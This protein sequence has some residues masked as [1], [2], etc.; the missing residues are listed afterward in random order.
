MKIYSL[1][2]GVD[3]TSGVLD[4]RFVYGVSIRAGWRSIETVQNKFDWSKIDVPINAAA[5][6]NKKVFFRVMVGPSCPQ[7]IFDDPNIPRVSFYSKKTGKTITTPVPWDKKYL[8]R[9]YVFCANLSAHLSKMANVELIA[10]SG[11][12]DAAAN[13][14]LEKDGE[15]EYAKA[16]YTAQLWTDT[17]KTM[18]DKHLTYFSDKTV[19]LCPDCEDT[20]I[21]QDLV[22]YAY[23]KLNRRRITIQSNGLNGRTP[24]SIDDPRMTWF[25]QYIGKMVIGFQMCWSSIGDRLGSLDK[26]I[27]DG[28]TLGAT[29]FEIYEEDILDSQY[30]L[31][32]TQTANRKE[33]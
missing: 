25:N 17:W 12:A 24:G 15:I 18:I 13:P 4:K 3:I 26:A 21:S 2:G 31:L 28:I 5:T 23:S 8:E 19:S 33:V 30:N 10:I 16:G 11:A 6:K 1:G 29:Y 32:F 22:A 9:Y 7:Y 20:K 27:K 14:F